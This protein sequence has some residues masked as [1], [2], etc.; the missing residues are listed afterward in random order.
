M[1]SKEILHLK[2]CLSS[3]TTTITQE[4]IANFL[5]KGRY[6]YHLRKLRQT[7]H[8]NSLKYI[9][10]IGEYFPKDTRVTKPQ[11]SFLLWVELN[12]KINV[13]EVFNKAKEKGGVFSPGT[14]FTL[15]NQYQNCMRLSYGLPWSAKVEKAL[16]ELGK[17]L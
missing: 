3:S 16:K 13:K 1:F 7:L 8:A 14:I 6:D 15:Q 2:L 11:G 10:T 12:P 4:T 5:M 17:F 9:A